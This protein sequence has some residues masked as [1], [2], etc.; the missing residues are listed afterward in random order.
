MS[1]KYITY[2]IDNN[3]ECY[4]TYKGYTLENLIKD[5][6]IDNYYILKQIHSNKVFDITNLPKNYE[7]DGLITNKSNIALVTK[8]KDC[9]SIFIIDTK[10]K[11]LGNIH[12]GWKGTLKS[13]ITIAINQ[14]KEKY[15]SA[16]KDIKIVFNPS[17]RECCFE[18][19]N[20]VYDLFIKKYK[21]K[22]YY[23]KVGNKYHM[24]LVRIIK[25]DAKKLGIK[26]ENII[27]NNICTLCNRKLFNSHRNNDIELNYALIIKR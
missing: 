7:G 4:Y 11:I 10:N 20:D 8:S 27:D 17:I 24:N 22:S 26:E 15:N 23:Q 18:V 16:S 5:L 2:N 12:S 3:I 14:M 6:N 25:D 21:D 13:I 9:N 1:E 19:D